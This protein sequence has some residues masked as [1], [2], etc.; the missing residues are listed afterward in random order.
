MRIEKFP[1][2]E[3]GP[4][5]AAQVAEDLIDTIAAKGAA[6]IALPGG[7]TPAFF[8]RALGRVELD[9]DKVTVTLTDERWVPP[10]HHRS[11]Q[12]LLQETLFQG[13]AARATLI[14]FY[15][16]GVASLAGLASQIAEIL[17]LDI[18]VLGM[19][20]D[21]HTASLFPNASGLDAALADE[22]MPVVRLILPEK[23]QNRVSLSAPVLRNA[24]KCYILIKG[25]KKRLALD[26]ALAANSPAEAPIRIAFEAAQPPVVFYAD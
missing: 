4:A 24:G 19:G 5:L 21:M 22:A 2:Q 3:L 26:R 14:P 20:E 12:R 13:H 8:L 1:E 23:Q 10:D 6:S 15:M 7:T 9:W 25:E 11:N 16:P 17:P 18:C